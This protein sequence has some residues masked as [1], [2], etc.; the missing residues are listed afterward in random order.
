MN[1]RQKELQFKNLV[2]NGADIFLFA[3]FCL[4]PVN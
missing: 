2:G 3:L 4:F 1:L